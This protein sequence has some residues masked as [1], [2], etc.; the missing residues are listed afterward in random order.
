[1]GILPFIHKW[2]KHT[3]KLSK[4]KLQVDWP[5]FASFPAMES[6]PDPFQPTNYKA[7]KVPHSATL[8]SILKDA[9]HV[10]NTCVCT[11]TIQHFG[12]RTHG[13]SRT[14]WCK[15]PL[16]QQNF[17]SKLAQ[18]RPCAPDG[19]NKVWTS[20]HALDSKLAKCD[21]PPWEAESQSD[22]AS[23]L[24]GQLPLSQSWSGTVT[25]G[26]RESKCAC[27]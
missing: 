13:C 23:P 6:S 17:L 15:L 12:N 7:R 10:G 5:H 24:A 18:Q 20:L 22:P 21:I 19:L 27:L 16:L 2:I 11:V 25:A 1:M 14:K 9:K 4:Y 26:K 3:P 8:Q